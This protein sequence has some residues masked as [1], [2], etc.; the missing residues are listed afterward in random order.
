M[1]D[2][3]DAPK[4]LNDVLS[5]IKGSKKKVDAAAAGKGGP[6][7]LAGAQ[8]DLASAKSA[9]G[10]L[11]KNKDRISGL[12]KKATG[13]RSQVTG[14]RDQ[15]ASAKGAVA[16]VQKGQ[17]G[18]V[19]GLP[20]ADKLMKSA[21][22]KLGPHADDASAGALKGF[23]GP[24]KLPQADANVAKA[25][26]IVEGL[27]KPLAAKGALPP[28]P[29]AVAL[30]ALQG[31]V[32][33]A[34]AQASA[35]AAPAT[36]IANALPAAQ[37][38]VALA[39][40]SITAM[41]AGP[42]PS[43]KQLKDGLPKIQS[44][45]GDAKKLLPDPK[46][47]KDL[48]AKVPDVSK[49][50]DSSQKGAVALAKAAGPTAAGLTSTRTLAAAQTSIESAQA[51]L[52]DGAKAL[53]DAGGK[54]PDVNAPVDAAKDVMD[55]I[56]P[57]NSAK[58][59]ER[60]AVDA[61]QENVAGAQSDATSANDAAGKAKDALPDTQKKIADAQQAAAAV[62]TGGVTP[63]S[64]QASVA[65]AQ[66]QAAVLAPAMA[67]A[68]SSAEPL[69]AGIAAAQ[70]KIT[71]LQKQL[72]SD[73]DANA[74][75]DAQKQLDELKKDAAPADQIAAAEA[76]VQELTKP[77]DQS[78]SKAPVAGTSDKAQPAED[79][80]KLQ[81]DVDTTAKQLAAMQQALD[82]L[83]QGKAPADQI[84]AAEVKVQELTK[85]LADA[86]RKSTTPRK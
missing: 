18:A 7:A 10:G 27:N 84:A 70:D 23:K 5:L 63:Q 30:S 35:V 43:V 82:V 49:I 37:Q 86:K 16:A 79:P 11:T 36:G 41:L 83:K 65:A 40:K 60:N 13:V 75:E 56:Q 77:V 28:A 55:S 8:E 66:K 59:P 20:S 85:K 29:D 26:K 73:D 46:A 31:T 72:G 3:K 78:K 80:A 69:T 58:D 17:T 50:A 53:T 38:P 45:I 4:S 76:R 61:L 74:L 54:M 51:K 6:E 62:E 2:Q 67:D 34:K 39:Q 32:G 1:A 24:E 25:E 68:Q 42:G 44:T 9:A 22:D 64:L 12:L 19:V 47:L 14:A 33:N 57:D 71:D 21:T 15:I 48:A 81:A 52:P